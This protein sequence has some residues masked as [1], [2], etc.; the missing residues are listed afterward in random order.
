L[1]VTDE[2]IAAF[3]LDNLPSDG[4]PWYD[5]IDQGVHFRNRDTS[6]AAILAGGLLRLSALTK[7]VE[8]AARYRREGERIIQSLID[9]YLSPA[10]VL[11]HGCTTRPFDGMTIYGDYYLLESLVWL[12]ASH[13][14]G[15]GPEHARTIINCL[16]GIS[17]CSRPR[18]SD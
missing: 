16:Q 12:E 8:N 1:L 4:V 18:P 3:A 10:G 15:H 5:F 6:A 13:R 11:K 7:D 2:K 17:A 14:A 9:R